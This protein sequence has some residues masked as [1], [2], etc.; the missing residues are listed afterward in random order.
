MFPGGRPGLGKPSELG[1]TPGAFA[2]DVLGALGG[3]VAGLTM[4]VTSY[5]VLN[6]MVATFATMVLAAVLLT[7]RAAT[8]DDLLTPAPFGPVHD[9]S[10]SAGPACER[11][12]ARAVAP[13]GEVDD[14]AVRGYVLSRVGLVH[15]ALYADDAMLRRSLVQARQGG[16]HL[17]A[18]MAYQGLAWDAVL[19]RDWRTARRWI[20][21]GIAYLEP[22]EILG[23]LQ[24]LRGLGATTELSAGDWAA[25]ESA[26]RW[27]LA[28]RVGR[29]IT[30]VHA[31]ATL[32]RLHVRRGETER[33]TSLV[34]EVWEVVQSTRSPGQ[35]ASR[36]DMSSWAAS[37]RC[38][39][40]SSTSSAGPVPSRSAT[41]CAVPEGA[42]CNPSRAATAIPAS[43]PGG[44]SASSTRKVE[45]SSSASSSSST[46]RVFP[47]PPGPTT[48][49]AR[50][51]AS[52]VRRA[53]ARSSGR[54]TGRA[55]RSGAGPGG[56]C[57]A[58]TSGSAV[59][60]SCSRSASS[61]PG[62]RPVSSA[63]RRR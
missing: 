54:R 61:A 9:M 43:P 26:A 36:W 15:A 21:E 34:R 30:G 13:A 48:V 53:P 20:G 62:S 38:A 6:A 11:I 24:Y 58:G 28:Q 50:R 14:P 22:R 40:L 51:P 3:S 47:T 8:C 19:R 46:R 16:Q 60:R 31:L 37:R 2:R 10:R 45:P 5:G 56:G 12:M 4:A 42:A 39:Q 18:G 49:T 35:C 23:P 17:E 59:R 52:A 29:G 55:G 1:T 41:A 44:T 7:G 33:A 27:V 63:R 25:A 32:A 57:R